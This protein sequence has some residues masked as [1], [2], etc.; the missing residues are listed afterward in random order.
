M[1]SSMLLSTI[2]LALLCSLPTHAIT[3]GKA[4][5]DFYRAC[6]DDVFTTSDLA[7][8][9]DSPRQSAA[10]ASARSSPSSSAHH[11]APTMSSK[12]S[13]FRALLAASSDEPAKEFKSAPV[14]VTQ[15]ECQS[16]PILTPTHM[17]SNSVA[18]EVELL[19]VSLFQ[20]CNITLHEVAAC[21][22][23]PLLTAPVK[24]R[25]AK[26]GCTP[27]NFG[28]WTDVWVS[29]DCEEVGT[30]RLGPYRNTTSRVRPTR[31]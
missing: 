20:E 5:V 26:S 31:G 15:G 9:L 22:D 6:P 23:K 21:I 1:L 16:V 14:N 10:S 2:S 27:R 4:W 28:A 25:V 7:D 30:G 19:A 11:T 17:D 13:L 8:F 24:N 3:S 18:V 12:K 29:L